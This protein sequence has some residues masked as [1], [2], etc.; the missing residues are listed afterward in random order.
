[1]ADPYAVDLSDYDPTNTDRAKIEDGIGVPC[2]ICCAAFRRIRITWR[3]C[4]ECNRAF[5]EGEHGN[6]ARGGRGTCVQVWS[7]FIRR[8]SLRIISSFAG[9][10]NLNLNC[11]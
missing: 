7:A 9:L 10:H 1:M 4:A 3:Y 5:C 8:H 2:R 11:R 6:F